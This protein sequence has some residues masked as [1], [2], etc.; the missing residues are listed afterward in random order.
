MTTI[1]EVVMPE[2]GA[3]A[4][5]RPMSAVQAAIVHRDRKARMERAER[6]LRDRGETPMGRHNRSP[7]FPWLACGNC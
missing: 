6:E 1:Y 3:S 2:H 7:T 5:D 4:G